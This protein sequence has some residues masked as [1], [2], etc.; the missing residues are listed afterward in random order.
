M[1]QKT[2]KGRQ[3]V[4]TRTHGLRQAARS[5]LLMID[6]KRSEAELRALMPPA[7]AQELDRLL[8]EG[9][10]ANEAAAPAPAAPTP[11]PPQPAAA[12]PLQ[13][14]MEAA[15]A[16]TEALGPQGDHLALRIERCK[17]AQEL[18]DALFFA[19]QVMGDLGRSRQA[20]AFAERF[21]IKL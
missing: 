11:A 3:E 18:Q 5:V 14:R 13:K 16:V 12:D 20:Q 10:V 9:F 17:T 1:L 6:G 21:Q 7:L 2:E 19:Y 15:R 8:Q 4:A